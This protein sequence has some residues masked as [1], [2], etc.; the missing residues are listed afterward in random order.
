MD[1]NLN[2][3]FLRVLGLGWISDMN[4]LFL[5]RLS[6]LEFFEHCMQFRIPYAASWMFGSFP[7]LKYYLG[8]PNLVPYF[9][10]GSAARLVV[11]KSKELPVYGWKIDVVPK[12]CEAAVP[13]EHFDCGLPLYFERDVIFKISVYCA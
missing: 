10:P 7:Q 11:I 13:I 8:P 12:L 1:P 2:F 6:K 4:I 3:P 5:Q 9:I